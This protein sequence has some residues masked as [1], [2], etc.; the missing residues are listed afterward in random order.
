MSAGNIPACVAVSKSLKVLTE[1]KHMGQKKAPQ[2]I[3]RVKTWRKPM[4]GRQPAQGRV[5]DEGAA[6][7]QFHSKEGWGVRAKTGNQ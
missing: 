5:K 1:G 4:D 7:H 2:S 3:N 6:S